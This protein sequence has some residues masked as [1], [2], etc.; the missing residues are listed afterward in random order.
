MPDVYTINKG[1]EHYPA[2]LTHF[3]RTDAPGSIWAMGNL[4]ILR[5]NKTAFFCS[6]KCPGDLIIKTYGAGMF[7]HSPPR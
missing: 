5:E 1:D 6:S 4:D 3:L 2:S 7:D